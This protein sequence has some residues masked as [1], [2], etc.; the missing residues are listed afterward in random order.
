MNPL[1]KDQSSNEETLTHVHRTSYLIHP[2]I[3]ILFFCE[4]LHKT[5][6]S[7]QAVPI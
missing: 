7:L 5:Q 1:G 2:I 6:I 4:H 3:N